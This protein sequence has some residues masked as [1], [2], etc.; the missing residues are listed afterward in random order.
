MTSVLRAP[1]VVAAAVATVL[2]PIALGHPLAAATLGAIACALC[3]ALAL[4]SAD[5]PRRLMWSATAIA[6][7]AMAVR[8]LVA[9]P[10][11]DIW[12]VLVTIAALREAL[13][14]PLHDLVPEPESGILLG[15]VLGERAGIGR[16]LRDA[17][18]VSGTAHLLAI[19]GFNMTLVASAVALVLRGRA[20]PA[21]VAAA[22]VTAVL[23]YSALV[24]PAASV[25]RAALMATVGAL[26][27]AL[28]RRGAAANALAAA[29]VAMLLA[30]P[31]AILDV[32]FLLSVA[33][34]AGLIA[35]HG[36]LRER[37]AGMPAFLADGLA[38]T[39]AASAPTVPIV[40]G[41][42]GRI[43]LVS[44]LANL[45]AV[46]LF[47]PIMLF[48]AATAAVGALAPAVAW[49]LAMAAYV[50]ATALRRVVEATAAVP[51]A[52]VEVPPGAL[53]GVLT[54]VAIAV[55]V[56]LGPHASGVA[57]AIRSLTSAIAD[58]A[59]A[60]T[61]SAA[62]VATTTGV[63]RAGGVAMAVVCIA[64]LV[65]SAVLVRSI[66]RSAAMRVRALDVGQGDAFLVESDG[67]YALIDGGPEPARLLRALGAVLPPW[68]RRIDL[69]ALTHEHADHGA[70]LLAVL[71][72]YE[73]G[74]AIEPVGMG[75]VPLVRSWADA[76]SRAGVRRVALA[77]GASVRVGRV[78][79]R[80]L[81]PG[82]DRRVDVPS[83][84]LL[85]EGAGRGGGVPRGG[86]RDPDGQGSVLFMGD[87]TDVQIADLL[88]APASL[89]AR[90][91]VPP[92]HGAATVHAAA[93]VEA[94]RPEAALLSV[95]ASNRYGHPA[96]GTIAAL[97]RIPVYRTD[98]HGTVEIELDGL[99]IAVRTAKERVPP[100]RG[101]SV[102]GAPA[103]R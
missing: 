41:V 38:A 8:A 101:G 81:A 71:G 91:Y 30:D 58:R 14:V 2:A 4:A 59:R 82:R 18:A 94:V 44:P 95:G 55:A 65:T 17:F 75:D 37:L 9:P 13:A 48:G 62:L 72:R 80:V 63:P 100:D 53:T 93:L 33:A 88:L 34:S 20:R 76:A 5:P 67:R 15:I 97:A 64:V 40:V 85:A 57:H 11:P 51:F 98:R 26:G 103:A 77:E 83:L 25:A 56:K 61:T 68:H 42:F 47:A 31:A 102:P 70:G 78:T 45:V 74:V 27:L 21:V 35:W 1:L 24:G 79:F 87:A 7:G 73:V 89:G 36:P 60:G 99:R 49:P 10:W 32:G 84:V 50:S 54:A 96:P 86:S 22:T 6:A 69:V 46:P 92:H 19:S 39:I 28:G 52:A 23:A 3:A 43:S 12:P 16:E 66:P 90:V 29:V